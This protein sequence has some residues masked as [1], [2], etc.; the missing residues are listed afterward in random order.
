MI[1]RKWFHFLAVALFGP[2]SFV[3]PQLM[4]LSYAIALCVLAVLES[5][6][7]DI[8]IL[9]SFYHTF[10]D[11]TKDNPDNLLVSHVFLILGCAMP[12]WIAEYLLVS[13]NDYSSRILL[14]QWGILCLGIGDA[15]GAIIGS[16]YGSKYWGR[17][18][19]T[20][21]GSFAMWL[22]MMIIGSFLAIPPNENFYCL[23]VATTL[24]TLLEA[25]TLQMDNLIL[26]LAGSLIIILV[27]S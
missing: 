9:Q 21:E 17:N 27:Q 16:L 7:Q 20:M 13:S 19:R 5:L 2:V 22:S 23:L 3:L 25:F 15:A 24:T 4:S 14:L 6:R 18:K 11:P 26:P 12:H 8:P 1:R 10:A